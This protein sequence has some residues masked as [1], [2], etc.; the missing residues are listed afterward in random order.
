MSKVQIDFLT[1]DDEVCGTRFWEH[2]PR[3]GDFMK[4]K[5]VKGDWY[6]ITEINWQG[7]DY[8]TVV[9]IIEKD[10]DQS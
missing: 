8:P 2:I 1:E 9:A 6:K 3:A 7:D 5:G 4:L 10:K